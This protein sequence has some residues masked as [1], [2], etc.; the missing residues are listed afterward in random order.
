MRLQRIDVAGAGLVLLGLSS[1]PAV[2]GG[3]QGAGFDGDDDTGA[4]GDDGSR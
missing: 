3:K 2:R 1:G 4:L